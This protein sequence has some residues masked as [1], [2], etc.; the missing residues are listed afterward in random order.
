MIAC[1]MRNRCCRCTCPRDQHG[2]LWVDPDRQPSE[3]SHAAEAQ[4]LGHTSTL[5]QAQGLRPFGRPFWADLP[6][7]DIS[8]ALTPDILHQLHKGVFR[9][10]LMN[11]CLA[12]V[13]K[14][15][16]DS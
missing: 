2:D 1:C 3:T 11:W 5:Y 8:A 16:V 13:E 4:A 15:H 14:A 7:C 6:H 12:L 9:E 10:H